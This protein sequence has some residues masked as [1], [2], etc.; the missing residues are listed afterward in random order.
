MRPL[1][2]HGAGHLGLLLLLIELRSVVCV[3]TS[4]ASHC[5]AKKNTLAKTQTNRKKKGFG[6]KGEFGE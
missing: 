2:V 1:S 3:F 4:D 5:L 6:K